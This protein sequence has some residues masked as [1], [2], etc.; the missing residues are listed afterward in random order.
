M[1]A[2]IKL[3]QS[4]RLMTVTYQFILLLITIWLIWNLTAMT[5]LVVTDA[6]AE[7]TTVNN[8]A[9]NLQQNKVATKQYNIR[10]VSD[11]HLFGKPVSTTSTVKQSKLADI[12]APETSLKLRLMGLRRGS[13]R[14]KSS[15]IVEGPNRKQDIYYMGDELPS[16][17]AIVE[18]IFIQ[19]MIISRQ[20]KY[21]TLT[22]FEVLKSKQQDLVEVEAASEVNLTDLTESIFVTG[23]LK[24]YKSM[25]LKDPVAVS[26]VMNIEPLSEGGEFKGY[27]LSPGIDRVFFR[28]AGLKKGD[29]LTSIN[30]VKLDSPNKVLSLLGSL[31]L[32]SDLELTIDRNGEQM[33]FRYTF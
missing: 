20:G 11:L 23:K 1:D 26:R 6:Q 8:A 7:S 18:E 30:D 29:V 28:K 21:E 27:T 2:T 25:A 17:K 19:H 24:K 15:A 14:I 5:W 13:G 16:G 12:K 33:S 4:Q 10:S 9:L 22:L 3:L 31:A 32:A